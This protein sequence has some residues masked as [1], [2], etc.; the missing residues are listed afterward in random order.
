MQF[1]L[2]AADPWKDWL[3]DIGVTS[4]NPIWLLLLAVVAPLLALA[5]RRRIYPHTPLAILA[6][7]PCALIVA[8]PLFPDIVWAVVALDGMLALVAAVDLMTLPRQSD[9]SAQRQTLHVASLQKPHRVTLTVDNHSRRAH[10]VWIRDDV[11]HEFTW[12][13]R[14][15]LLRLPPRSRSTISYN[16]RAGRRGKFRMDRV[17]FQAP[18]RWGLWKRHVPVPAKTELHVYPDMKQLSQYAILARTNRLSLMGVR[19]TRRVGQEN[20]FERLR[21]YTPDD[22]YKHIDWRSTARRN[23][24]TVKDFQTSQSQRLIFLIDCGRMMANE[25]AGLSLLDHA[26]N[27]MLMLSYVALGRGD[28]VGLVCFADRVVSHVPVKGG[29]RQTPPS[30]VFR[31]LSS[32]ATTRRSCTWRSG[33]ASARS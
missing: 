7:A 22:N 31:S 3:S 6:V 24:L 5:W 20:E 13:P 1:L 11:P 17:Y 12:Q 14:E 21:D 30:T 25:A 8:T 4:A 15:F 18:S 29:M 28:S 19:R 27:A 26:L 10:H 16:L 9:F 2:L 23:K 33:S 32:R